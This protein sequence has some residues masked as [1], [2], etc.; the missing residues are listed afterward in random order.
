MQ[1]ALSRD[2]YMHFA[3]DLAQEAS[4]DGEVPV[5]CV[6]VKD[7][8][9]IGRGRNRCEEKRDALCHAELEAIR[10][11]EASLG[12]WRLDGCQMYVTM[13]PCPMCA[14]A[15]INSRITEL[16]Y[17]VKDPKKGAVGSVLD[18]FSENF[19]HRVKVIPGILESESRAILKQFFEGIR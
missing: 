14:G 7:G 12:D 2:N 18:L 15:V 19:G 13:E 10:E 17:G 5:G 16:Y 1:M 11:A 6:I 3:L 8:N 9:I 4:A